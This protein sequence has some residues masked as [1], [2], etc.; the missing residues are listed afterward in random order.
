MAKARML[1][2]AVAF[3]LILSPAMAVAGTIKVAGIFTLPVEQ[4]W[5]SRIHI[6]LSAAEKRGE[7]EYV[8]SEN[9][10]NTDYE[11]V[12]REYAEQGV[13]L[14]VGEVFGLERAARK[15]A[16]DYPR[17]SLF[18]GLFFCTTSAKLL[19]IR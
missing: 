4:Q 11:R 9:V 14:I 17:N 2:A 19:Y 5:I 12:M 7:I 3:G 6:A 8:Y 18:N 10:S 16:A 1:M 15:V 13:D